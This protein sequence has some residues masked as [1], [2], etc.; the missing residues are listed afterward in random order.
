MNIER[1]DHPPRGFALLEIIAALSVLAVAIILV[2]QLGVWSLAEHSRNRARHTAQEL[3]ANILESARA[4]S[5]EELTPSWA[6]AQRLPEPF[7][8]REWQLD[9]RVV[10]EAAHPRTKRVTVEIRYGPEKDRLA[11]PVR[12]TGF[13]TTRSM[14]APGGKP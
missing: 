7:E 8:E 11:R 14:T 4:S 10:P 2:A 13:F 12:L 9:V 6:S 3:A 5:W 1:R